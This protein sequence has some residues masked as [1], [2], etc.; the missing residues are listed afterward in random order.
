MQT[1]REEV[2]SV[3]IIFISFIL[4]FIYSFF[5][6]SYIILDR[7]RYIYPNEILS[8]TKDYRIK[9]LCQYI[10]LIYIYNLDRSS[11]I[12]NS[13]LRPVANKLHIIIVGYFGVIKFTLMEFYYIFL[14]YFIWYLRF[15]ALEVT[16]P[17]AFVNIS[18][19][20]LCLHVYF[21]IL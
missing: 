19:A 2:H 21:T 7:Y 8:N 1:K 9:G 10:L 13:D 16:H 14:I 11:P 4:L 5:I 3:R 17:A 6:H 12:R 18:V 20:S 15:Y